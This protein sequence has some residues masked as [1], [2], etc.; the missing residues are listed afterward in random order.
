M[1][2]IP[3]PR[4][5]SLCVFYPDTRDEDRDTV[6]A[7]LLRHAPARC[8]VF[9]TETRH[10]YNA[11]LT[12]KLRLIADGETV[13]EARL[14]GRP[15]RQRPQDAGEVRRHAPRQLVTEGAEYPGLLTRREF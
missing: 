6:R 2:R 3:P 4:C 1:P 15:P 5:R 7:K 11:R 10:R 14:C 9:D 13:E 8:L 12:W